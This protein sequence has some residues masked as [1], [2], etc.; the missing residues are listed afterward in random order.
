MKEEIVMRAEER[1]S[2]MIFSKWTWLFLIISFLCLITFSSGLSFVFCIPLIISV[3]INSKVHWSNICEVVG[4]FGAYLFVFSIA[5]GQLGW[6]FKAEWCMM[7]ALIIGV[8]FFGR[9]LNWGNRK[10]T[11]YFVFLCVVISISTLLAHY[12]GTGN[13]KYLFQL[14]ITLFVPWMMIQYINSKIK[15]RWAL[16]IVSISVI[17]FL[18]SVWKEFLI[19]MVSNHSHHLFEP[20]SYLLGMNLITLETATFSTMIFIVFFLLLW[21]SKDKKVQLGWSI[22][23][24]LALG[25]MVLSSERITFVSGLIGVILVLLFYFDLRK[26]LKFIGIIVVCLIILFAFHGKV[27]TLSKYTSRISTITSMNNSSN[28]G[29][30]VMWQAGIL[31]VKAHPIYG[32]GYWN[33]YDMIRSYIIRNPDNP[34]IKKNTWAFN[35]EIPGRPWIH[36]H[37]TYL[38]MFVTTGIFGILYFI[39]FLG[40]VPVYLYKLF[41][42]DGKNLLL[43][44]LTL[45]FIAY[46]IAGLTD[47]VFMVWPLL[48]D[49]YLLLLFAVMYI[50]RVGKREE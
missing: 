32:V 35:Q 12:N 13:F 6:I 37:N 5:I 23:T 43:V 34:I 16:F 24:L 8:I 20:I 21:R 9:Q 7:M 25:V 11:L 22:C 14:N 27:H 31:S 30:F 40:I 47:E 19:M 42:R 38:E 33:V 10:L 48:K 4:I 45:L 39:L 3:A 15:F 2:K 36:V 17:L 46:Y 41:R 18:G 50:D 1:N 49:S 44:G 28:D 29:R 26:T